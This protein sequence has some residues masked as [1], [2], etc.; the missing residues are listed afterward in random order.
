MKEFIYCAFDAA[1][2]HVYKPGLKLHIRNVIRYGGTP[3][4][5]MEVLEIATLV[6]LQGVS[7]GMPIMEEELK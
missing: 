3:E 7:V 1:C 2:Q 4:E 5:I 6:G